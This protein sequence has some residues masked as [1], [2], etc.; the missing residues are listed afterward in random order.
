MSPEE[1]IQVLKESP[2][3][4]VDSIN[5]IEAIER[6]NID[7]QIATAKKYPR[8]L[9]RVKNDILSTATLD[10]ETAE[11]C[12]YVL[13]ARGSE[14][15]KP[16]QGASVR[17]AEIAVSCFGNIKAG[18]RIISNDGNFVTAQGICHDVEKNVS[19]SVE[20]RRSI[21]GKNG[22]TYSD[23]MIQVTSQAA[24]AIAYRNAVF[25]V[26]PLALVKPALDKAMQLAK[27]D[28]KSLSERRGIMVDKFAKLGITKEKLAERVGKQSI[29]EITL[30]DLQT[31][32][33]CYNALKDG[34]AA[35]DDIFP[36]TKK[37]A[38]KANPFADRENN[39]KSPEKEETKDSLL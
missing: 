24:C 1:S 9:A 23:N 12:F 2:I 10:E 5:P 30:D 32:T 34:E 33:G 25:K 31:L 7:I 39:T 17:L 22:K 26:V 11:S 20:V 37:E 28:I 38:P 27:G 4:V 15:G 29:E 8:S 14:G 16:I 36:A 6:A 21:K 3:E 19:V 18:A 35:V 13:P